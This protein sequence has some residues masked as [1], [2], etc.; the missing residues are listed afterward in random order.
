MHRN[1]SRRSSDP[2]RTELIRAGAR[3][4]PLSKA[5]FREV[6]V[7]L[8]FSLQPVWVETT[9]DRDK[10][11]SLR[12]LDKTDFFTRELDQMLLRAQIDVAIHS[13]KDL[14]EPIPRGLAVVAIT[15]GVD[16][17]DC[18]VLRKGERLRPGAIIATSSIRREEAVK[19]MC[20]DVQFIDLRG[21]IGE[22]LAKLNDGTADGVVLAEAALI[23]LAL[24]H[25]HRIFLP[26]DGVSMQGRLA[27]TAREG[28]V[29]MKELFA[30]I[31]AP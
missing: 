10:S 4:S 2:E 5:Q 29:E 14:P 26:I 8:G 24:T 23:R 22:R 13:A 31:H 1:R 12:T 28:D 20:N 15:K 17:R 21:T 16:S 7:E 30:K 6:E 25:L 19:Q 27:V 3:S 11:T 9:G 18:L